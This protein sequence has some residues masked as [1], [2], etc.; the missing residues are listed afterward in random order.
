[1]NKYFER[2]IK[3]GGDWVADYWVEFPRAS[4][5]GELIVVVRDDTPDDV[6]AAIADIGE[7]WVEHT[8]SWGSWVVIPA[9]AYLR[10]TVGAFINKKVGFADLKKA[11]ELTER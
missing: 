10:E 9:T 6:R 7:E 4:S 2:M 3:V 8:R 5:E 1:M 11:Y